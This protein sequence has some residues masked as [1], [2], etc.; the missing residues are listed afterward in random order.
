MLSCLNLLC[1]SYHSRWQM[2]TVISFYF[3]SFSFLCKLSNFWAKYFFCL[4][5]VVPIIIMQINEA[6]LWRFPFPRGYQPRPPR[7][8][9]FWTVDSTR[10]LV[11]SNYGL[12]LVRTMRYILFTFVTSIARGMVGGKEKKM[13]SCMYGC[14]RLCLRRCACRPANP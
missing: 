2:L 5:T 8:T 1:C 7:R 4:T 13:W 6:R 11:W 14:R 3:L 9:L 12:C 10:E